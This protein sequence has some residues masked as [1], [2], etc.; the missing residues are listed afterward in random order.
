MERARKRSIPWLGGNA[1]A[2]PERGYVRT[3]NLG[4]SAY[5]EQDGASTRIRVEAYRNGVEYG[6]YVVGDAEGQ[7]QA[8]MHAG[9]WMKLRDA[10]DAEIE[11]MTTEVD[12]AIQDSAEAIG[13]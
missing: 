13:L 6:K 5:I 8:Y 11:D 7:G 4:R 1:Y 3:G 12:T 9:W 2:V 10:V